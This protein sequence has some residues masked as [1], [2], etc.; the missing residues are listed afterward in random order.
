M[1][2][3][4]FITP[5]LSTGGQPQYLY[6]QIESLI[7]EYEVY[8]IE[9][10]NCTGG[11]LVVQRNRI[12]KL[13]GKRLIT[14]GTNKTKILSEIKSISP[15]IIHFQEIPESFIESDTLDVGVVVV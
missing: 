1:Q 8:C 14:I 3:L 4:L 12:E 2:K 13:L 7:N 5:H 15:D 11:V 10:E 6:K 9:W